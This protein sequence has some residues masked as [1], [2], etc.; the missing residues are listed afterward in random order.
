ME[1]KSIFADSTEHELAGRKIT[2]RQISIEDLPLVAE[3]FSKV[4]E[5]NKL[6]M[7]DKIM[8]MVRN[9]FEN[10]KLLIVRLSDIKEDEVSKLNLAAMIFI[11]QK[12]IEDNASFLDQVVA[13][14]MQEMGK[15][16]GGLTK[17][18]S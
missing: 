1:L 9:E 2:I 7:Q 4:F 11:I 13:P 6:T 17:S 3:L 5:K 12:I 16:L 18:K 15:S 8:Q 10:V 14:M